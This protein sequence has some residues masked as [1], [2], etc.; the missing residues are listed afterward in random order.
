MVQVAS[1]SSLAKKEID[2]KKGTI[3]AGYTEN[4]IIMLQNNLDK[5]YKIESQEKIAQALLPEKLMGSDQV[6]EEMYQ[7]TLQKKTVTK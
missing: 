3:N 2:I 5:F 7:S 6:E 1:Q 4:I